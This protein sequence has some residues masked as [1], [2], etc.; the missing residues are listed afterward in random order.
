VPV[1]ALFAA[2]ALALLL[3]PAAAATVPGDNGRLVFVS[4][5]SGTPEIWAADASG[6]NQQQLTS[7][8]NGYAQ[9]PSQGP[10][11]R[12]AYATAWYGTRWFLSVMNADGSDAHQLWPK[13]DRYQDFDDGRTAWSPDGQWILFSST[14]PF[15]WAWNLWL[16]RPDGSQL[17]AL[18]TDWGEAPDWSPDGSRIAYEGLDSGIGNVIKVM[19]AAGGGS[20]RLTSGTQPETAP[21]WSPDGTKIAFGRYTS[22]YRTSNAHAIFV[23]D[24]DGSNERQLTFGGSYDDHAVWSPDGQWILFDR[25]GQLYKI[26]PDGTGLTQ[27]TMPATNYTADWAPAWWPVAPPPPPL[28]PP[29]PPPPDTTPPRITIAFPAGDGATVLLGAVVA[30]VYSCDDDDSGVASCTPKPAGDSLYTGD[31]G[32]FGFTVVAAD[33]AGNQSALTHRYQVVYR[34]SGFQSP[35][36]D[37]P[38]LNQANAGQSIPFRFSLAGPQ[39]SPVQSVAWQTVACDTLAPLDA[40]ATPTGALT[41][42]ATL[43]RWTFEAATERAWAGSCRR[44]DLGLRDGTRHSAYVRFTK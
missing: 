13:P 14:R 25:A 6:Q 41:Y 22:D 18:T 17:H 34:W 20:H 8:P 40:P 16:V 27:V 24:A 19:D 37:A 11:G 5:R 23:I 9:W 38:E 39:T 26:R 12:I 21:S 29:P 33:R 15:N 10:D 30:P 44:F 28:P 1:R 3:A 7:T 42:N 31:V 43:D 35:V 4:T 36:A 32:T 2:V